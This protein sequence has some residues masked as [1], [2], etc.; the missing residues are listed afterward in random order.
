M[1]IP[2]PTSRSGKRVYLSAWDFF[3]A[4]ASPPL[5]LYLHDPRGVFFTDWSVVALFWALSAGFALIAFFAFRL[6]DGMTRYFSMHEAIDVAEAVLFSELMTLFAIFTLTRLDGIPRSIPILHG[7]L[8][9][10]GLLAA[11]I[12]VRVIFT[13]EDTTPAYSFRQTRMIVIGANPLASSFIR[14]LDAFAA[15][16]QSVVG[17]LDARPDMRG[18]AVSGVRVLGTPNELDAVIG[19]FSIHGVDAD[20]VIVAGEAQFLSPTVLQEIERVCRK[21]QLQ[22]SFLPRMMGVTEV[23]PSHLAVATA[24]EQTFQAASSYFRLKRFIDVVGASALIVLL[25]PVFVLVGL[26]VCLDVGRPVFFWQERLGWKGRSFLIYKFRTLRV[27]LGTDVNAAP[28]IRK[29]SLIGRLLRRTRIDEL[30]QLFNVLLGDMALV[31]P[32]PLLPEDQPP[33][34]SVR[35]SV[36]PGITGWAQIKGGKLVTAEEKEKFDDWYVQNA[37]LGLDLKIMLM[38]VGFLLKGRASSREALADTIQA[39][40]KNRDLQSSAKPPGGSATEP[41]E[42]RAR[43]NSDSLRSSAHQSDWP[44]LAPNRAAR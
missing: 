3:W 30:P 18:K 26:V 22:L 5:A 10:A 33:N 17:I 20:R 31:G 34:I 1:S 19:E 37:S 14:M 41:A 21:R 36:R 12:I 4:V 43:V 6:Q 44:N 24:P 7:V 28:Q 27:P 15:P 2:S 11:R 40:T 16:R 25:F 13:E 23:A 9:L 29:P 8:L 38:T 32:R 35:L 39:Q 42:L